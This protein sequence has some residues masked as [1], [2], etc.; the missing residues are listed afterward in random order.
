MLHLKWDIAVQVCVTSDSTA[1]SSNL[2]SVS[3]GVQYSV[4]F[5]NA[6]VCSSTVVNVSLTSTEVGE[7]L[8]R[9]GK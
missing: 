3:L 7:V 2:I 8:D 9:L 5:L 1:I 4:L 6:T